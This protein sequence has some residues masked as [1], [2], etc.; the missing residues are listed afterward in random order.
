MQ[1][2]LTKD[3]TGGQVPGQTG[4][5]DFHHFLDVLFRTML[6]LIVYNIGTKWLFCDGSSRLF[7][8][9]LFRYLLLPFFFRAAYT[10]SCHLTPLKCMTFR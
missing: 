5:N 7:S 4:G 10:S 2:V 3:Y 8:P 1:I 9:S 6:S